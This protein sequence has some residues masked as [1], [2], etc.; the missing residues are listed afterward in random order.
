MFYFY[1]N[2]FFPLCSICPIRLNFFLR[3]GYFFLFVE[4]FLFA[5][6]YCSWCVCVCA[7]DLTCS[8]RRPLSSTWCHFNFPC[9][10][11]LSFAPFLSFSAC[12]FVRLRRNFF[13]YY[14]S[15]H[16]F[17]FFWG[18]IFSKFLSMCVR[19]CVCMMFSLCSLSLCTLY[20]NSFQFV[21]CMRRMIFYF[22]HLSSLILRIYFIVR[23][24][25][26]KV[27]WMYFQMKWQCYWKWVKIALAMPFERE[28]NCFH[29]FSLF[30]SCSNV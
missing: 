6:E 25:W 7:D 26:I 30:R 11:S 2:S 17:F 22:L 9:A 10:W 8:F 1:W 13:S 24:T 18:S 14:Y 29:S 4:I 21:F 28:Y 23:F 19:V 27:K 16:F 15:V 5:E 3:L 20:L 12:I